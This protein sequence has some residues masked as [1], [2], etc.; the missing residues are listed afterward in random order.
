MR[1]Y[2]MTN[3]TSLTS[4]RIFYQSLIQ[5]REEL[6]E[7]MNDINEEIVP[8]G[9]VAV[10]LEIPSIII[11]DEKGAIIEV[12]ESGEML[13]SFVSHAFEQEFSKYIPNY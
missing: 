11:F 5:M 9:R 2:K 3:P 12:K 4:M 13:H 10:V 1:K 7:E 8:K 6:V